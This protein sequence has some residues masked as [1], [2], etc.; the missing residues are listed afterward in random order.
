M[1]VPMRLPICVC[2]F[3]E[4]SS[5]SGTVRLESM[6]QVLIKVQPLSRNS[7]LNAAPKPSSAGETACPLLPNSVSW[8]DSR[9]SQRAAAQCSN[10]W[11]MKR[12]PVLKHFSRRNRRGF[13]L[14]FLKGA[15]SPCLE[16]LGRDFL[17]SFPRRGLR[18]GRYFSNS[19][20]VSTIA[21]TR[22]QD[23]F[24]R[25]FSATISRSSPSY[26]FPTHSENLSVP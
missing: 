4:Q 25:I 6:K 18:G 1:P 23:K 15:P 2:M 26:S 20:H 12:S 17:P 11:R 14:P 22:G 5:C 10:F 24:E 13:I 21:K 7:S 3:R 19:I 8:S 16:G 9:S